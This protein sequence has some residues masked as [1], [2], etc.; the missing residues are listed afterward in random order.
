[1]KATGAIPLAGSSLHEARHVCAF[2][3][4]EE[5]EYRVLLPFIRD[6]IECGERAV[7][8]LNPDQEHEHVQRLLAAGI[9][10]RATQASGQLELRTNT[11]TYLRDGQFDADR[12]LDAFERMASGRA[13]SAYPR[14]RILCRMD[15]A[16]EAHID[17]GE[18]VQFEARVNE[19]WCRHDDAVICTYHLTKFGGDTVV[20]IMRTHPLVLLG[21]ILHRNPFFMPPEEFLAQYRERTRA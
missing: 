13:A 4:S 8:V 20:D 2:F 17:V 1:M 19:V 3:S 11:E 14:S 7:H 18:L 10:P 16:A 21:G 9:D 5:E 6:G 15:W 12:M